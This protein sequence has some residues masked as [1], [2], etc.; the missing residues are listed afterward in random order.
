MRQPN[1][2]QHVAV[3]C[4]H[5]INMSQM[6]YFDPFIDRVRKQLPRT[7]RTYA[8]FR[9][10]FW[11]D[12]V[13]GRQKDYVRHAEAMSDL[14]TSRL[15]RFVIEGLGDA[16]AYQKTRVQSSAYFQIQ[17]EI[18]RVLA[19]LDAETVEPRPLVFIG[20]S[21]GCH[22]ISSYAWDLNKLKHRAHDQPREE[23]NELSRKLDPLKDYSPF[24]R[25]ETFAGFVTMGS[26][27]PL[28]TFTF[29]PQRV[30]PIT[31]TNDPAIRPAFPGIALKGKARE[32]ARWL[33]FYSNRDVLGYPLK[34]LNDTYANDPRIKDIHVATGRWSLPPWST[35]RAHTGYRENRTVIRET[36]QLIQDLIEAI[37][38]VEQPATA[39]VQTKPATPIAERAPAPPPIPKPVEA[40][41]PAATDKRSV[42]S[43]LSLTRTK[44]A[45]E[46]ASQLPPPP[47]LPQMPAQVPSQ[48]QA[49]ASATRAKPLL[50]TLARPAAATAPNGA[51]NGT[52]HASQLQAAGSNPTIPP[53]AT[54]TAVVSTV[55]P[56]PAAPVVAQVS[57]VPASAPSP[58][59]AQSAPPSTQP[60][61]AASA[62]AAAAANQPEPVQQPQQSSGSAPPIPH[63][64]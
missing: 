27:M 62:A 10:V 33:N 44:I 17:A 12:I 29:G 42:L 59:P 34:P 31:H 43:S 53:Q 57:G 35:I 3:V 7:H 25:L 50:P 30:Y 22:I 52:Q 37:G 5:G 56:G 24:R 36:A 6:D 1:K 32:R 55:L 46:P 26:N 38:D 61:S 11:A 28:F 60:V 15:R 45:K 64:S 19:E 23:E 54:P 47:P 39:A 21:L 16:A 13:R 63:G 48:E 58:P 41:A 49:D 14:K 9:N 18:A 51:G 4:V 20:H 8:T 2:L 40:L